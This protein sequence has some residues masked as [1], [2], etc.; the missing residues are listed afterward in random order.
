MLKHEKYNTV[1]FLIQTRTTLEDPTL[2]G[3]GNTELLGMDLVLVRA[4]G[5]QEISTK[6][7]LQGSRV[8]SWDGEPHGPAVTNWSAFQSS[9]W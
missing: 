2:L 8:L 9:T 7:S 5:E 1:S 4:V 3:R 6:S